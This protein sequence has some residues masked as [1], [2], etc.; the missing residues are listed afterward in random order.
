MQNIREECIE[1]VLS[2]DKTRFGEVWSRLE[3]SRQIIA[4]QA[5]DSGATRSHSVCLGLSRVHHRLL[6][7]LKTTAR[8]E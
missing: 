3:M 7:S 2:R 4:F 6:H 5:R 8:S 1:I